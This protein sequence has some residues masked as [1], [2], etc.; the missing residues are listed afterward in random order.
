MG[1]GSEIKPYRKFVANLCATFQ[2]TITGFNPHSCFGRGAT[3]TCT[4]SCKSPSERIFIDILCTF[5]MFYFIDS[6]VRVSIYLF[7][8]QLNIQYARL[9]RGLLMQNV[10]NIIYILLYHTTTIHLH[11][12]YESQSSRYILLCYKYVFEF[13]ILES[14]LLWVNMIL[15][16]KRD[17]K[18]YNYI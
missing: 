10:Y 1:L 16:V 5:Y 14:Y 17:S 12:L 9:H 2:C 6:S 3:L 11:Y 7:P 15:P 4:M 8:V 18:N 13:Q